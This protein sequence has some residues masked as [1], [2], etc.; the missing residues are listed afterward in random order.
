[1]DGEAAFPDVVTESPIA[2]VASLV[3][4]LEDPPSLESAEEPLFDPVPLEHAD[5]RLPDSSLLRKS[6]R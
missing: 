6:R 5:Y 4:Q 1:M 3:D 2:P